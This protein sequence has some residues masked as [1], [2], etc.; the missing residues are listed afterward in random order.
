MLLGDCYLLFGL[1]WGKH[2]RSNALFPLT[3]LPIYFFVLKQQVGI[4]Y[5]LVNFGFV[6]LCIFVEKLKTIIED[7]ENFYQNV[8]SK[9]HFLL[10]V[11]SSSN[12]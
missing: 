1:V 8:L 5:S 4:Y 12:N 6:C 2:P 7:P 9:K 3:P 10:N 11:L